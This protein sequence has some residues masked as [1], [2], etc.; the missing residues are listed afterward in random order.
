MSQELFT[1]GPWFVSDGPGAFTRS[2]VRSIRAG[3]TL[4]MDDE[5]YNRRVPR[6][7]FDWHLIVAA[8]ELYDMVKKLIERCPDATLAKQA[9]TILSN[10]RG[11]Y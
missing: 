4:I 7:P 1:P 11:E 9:Y 3:N 2:H 6:N 10:A 5:N 8:P